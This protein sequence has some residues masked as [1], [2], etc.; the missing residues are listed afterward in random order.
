MNKPCKCGYLLTSAIIVDAE[1]SEALKANTVWSSG[2]NG[3]KRLIPS[4]QIDRFRKGEQV[5]ES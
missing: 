5:N 3:A 2:L 4:S 1:P